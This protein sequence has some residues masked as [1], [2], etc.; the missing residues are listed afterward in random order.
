MTQLTLNLKG[1]LEATGG[2]MTSS[3]Q[4][5]SRNYAN[6]SAMLENEKGRKTNATY[7]A[8]CFEQYK[9]LNRNSSSEKMYLVSQILTADWYSKRCALTWKLKGTKFSRLL[10]QLVPKTHRT[11]E[12]DAG[13]LEFAT[14]TN[15]NGFQQC[16]GDDEI[17]AS[18]RGINA[19]G[20]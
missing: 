7:G 8:R 20:N 5:A 18:E 9:K 16:N 1:D 19:F 13:L 2:T 6:H 4:V 10:F 15:G 12:I 11:D 17:N 14:N 3:S